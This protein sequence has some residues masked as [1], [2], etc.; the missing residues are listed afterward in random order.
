MKATFKHQSASNLNILFQPIKAPQ[1]FSTA[2][3]LI[4]AE[5][6][7]RISHTLLLAGSE[8]GVQGK[9]LTHITD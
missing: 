2:Y 9:R 3:T 7:T 8:S 6:D 5:S 4:S 1:T